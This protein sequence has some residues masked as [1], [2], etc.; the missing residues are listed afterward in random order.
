MNV[1]IRD[2]SRTCR[3]HNAH[4]PDNVQHVNDM[5]LKDR[6]V[7][8]KEISVE[9]GIGDASVYRILKQLGLR[10][11]C[12]VGSEDVDRCAQRDSKSCVHLFLAQ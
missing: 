5:V 10:C 1:N 2:Y 12:R 11:W 8:M 9:L 4:A 6:S 7:S 3:P